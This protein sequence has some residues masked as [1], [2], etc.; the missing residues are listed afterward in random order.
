M[1][2]EIVN[3]FEDGILGWMPSDFV[4]LQVTKPATVYNTYSQ[5]Q[6]YGHTKT[7]CGGVEAVVENHADGVESAEA[8]LYGAV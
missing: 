4:S 6:H 8:T 5:Q 7:A 3:D 2:V 1:E